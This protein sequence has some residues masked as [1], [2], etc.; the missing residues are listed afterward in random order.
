MAS[1]V[2][3]SGFLASWVWGFWMSGLK[4]SEFRGLGF[5]GLKDSVFRVSGFRVYYGLR[6]SVFVSRSFSLFLSLGTRK[7]C[8]C[9]VGM[10]FVKVFVNLSHSNA[11]EQCG[12]TVAGGLATMNLN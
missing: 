5:L 1:G 10:C 2:L 7:K 12:G 11:T 8:M 9:A 3:G 6:G 4:L